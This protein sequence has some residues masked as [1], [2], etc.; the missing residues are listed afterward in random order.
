MATTPFTIIRKSDDVTEICLHPLAD[1]QSPRTIV[2][3][4]VRNMDAV[5]QAAARAALQA[6]NV[7]PQ[8]ATRISLKA[9]AIPFGKS[10]K[11]KNT[12]PSSFS[13]VNKL[14]AVYDQGNLGSCVA[15]AT[16][17]ALACAH[18][19]V[20][21]NSFL[22]SRLF[23]Y[24]IGRA[25]DSI[26]DTDPSYLVNDVGLYMNSAL[27]AVSTY[28]VCTESVLPYTVSRFAYLPS[29]THFQTASKNRTITYTLLPKTLLA[30]KTVL[31]AGTS[32]TSSIVNGLPVILG[33][34]VYAN[35]YDNSNG[36]IPMPAGDVLG[37]HAITLIGYNDSES[38]FL[39]RNSWGSSWGTAGNGTL[40][41]AYVL[42]EAAFEPYYINRWSGK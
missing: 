4:V 32:T 23:L 8:I 22:S 37:G 17:L 2:L 10:N 18:F 6:H 34:L 3:N 35:F 9:H 39:F 26:M 19:N 1:G 30:I 29:L 15:N 36:D 20:K 14:P 31:A 28:G 13:L 33:I 11:K 12:L 41:Y 38:T 16:A 40:P 7:I 5:P 24:F 27:R 25:L 21:R 42:S